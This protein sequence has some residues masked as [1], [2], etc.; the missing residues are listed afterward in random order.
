M[1][2]LM[3]HPNANMWNKTTHKEERRRSLI[4]SIMDISILFFDNIFTLQK[5][6]EPSSYLA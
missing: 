2:L 5:Y 3:E 4:H 6:V 1:Y